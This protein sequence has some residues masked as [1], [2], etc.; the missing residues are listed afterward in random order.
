MQ[1]RKF[2]WK[3]LYNKA[4]KFLM[5]LENATH[6]LAGSYDKLKKQIWFEHSTP[7]HFF[8]NTK[9]SYSRLEKKTTSN[10]TTAKS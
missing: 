2:M 10:S 8:Q 1:E 9:Y 6:S 3:H 5:Q 7:I 4:T